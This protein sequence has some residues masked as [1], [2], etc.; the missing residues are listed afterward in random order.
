V[1]TIADMI[2]SGESVE[3]SPRYMRPSTDSRRHEASEA[4]GASDCLA[5]RQRLG[6]SVFLNTLVTPDCWGVGDFVAL[7][8]LTMA[9]QA[10]GFDFVFLGPAG[11]CSVVGPVPASPYSPQSRLARSILHCRPE[12]IDGWTEIPAPDRRALHEAA[13]K[14]NDLPLLDLTAA[15]DLKLAALRAI[16][17]CRREEITH[18]PAFAA[19]CEKR[20]SHVPRVAHYFAMQARYGSDWQTWPPE[21]LDPPPAA[22]SGRAYARER[23]FFM[24]CQWQ[25]DRQFIR[26]ATVG[27]P[28]VTDL[29]VGT[30]HASTDAWLWREATL[31]QL[32]LGSPADYFN[33]QGHR[34]GL[35]PVD[36][37]QLEKQGFRPLTD[38]LDHALAHAAGARIDHAFGLIRLYC[39]DAASGETPVWLQQPAATASVVTERARSAGGFI[40]TEELGTPPPGADALLREHGFLK[41]VPFISDQFDFDA[42]P[43]VLSASCHDLPTLAGCLRGQV[44]T[45]TLDPAFLVRAVARIR[46]LAP[47]ADRS[48]PEDTA[49]VVYRALSKLGS[50]TLLV[51]PE[52]VLGIR[53]P[54]NLP[55][56]PESSWPS[57]RHRLPPL[58][59]LLNA[60]GLTAVARELSTSFGAR[61][62]DF[63]L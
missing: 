44:G 53:R 19:Y 6:L 38:A 34:W 43:D 39:L 9:L 37:A 51:S 57:F 61:S 32:Q 52:D 46:A 12:R 58:H 29:P 20:T 55:G 62:R 30:P 1:A 3:P 26:A 11:A 48:E 54:V 14:L 22:A 33:P 7:E 8:E 16:F 10:Y 36:P 47:E 15:R 23:L 5:S 24:W 13:S 59:E 40:V 42:P 50:Q 25:L 63:R 56:V 21:L 45:Q 41:Q 28:I 35:V 17:E 18:D 4:H 2:R 31:P 27:V 60:P 49:P